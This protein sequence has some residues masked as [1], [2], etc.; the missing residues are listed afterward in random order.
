MDKSLGFAIALVAVILAFAVFLWATLPQPSASTAAVRPP[1]VCAKNLQRF[2]SQTIRADNGDII[3][4]VVD[5]MLG[6]EAIFVRTYNSDSA[7]LAFTR[8][9]PKEAAAPAEKER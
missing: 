8:D 3:T 9:L 2:T 4:V 7:V 6:K 1:D 5:A